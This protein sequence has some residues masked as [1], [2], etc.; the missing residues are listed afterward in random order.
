MDQQLPIIITS[1]TEAAFETKYQAM[2]DKVAEMGI[3][4]VIALYN[5]QLKTIDSR[6]AELAKR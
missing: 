1:K 2:V 4:E 3:D 6:I 5:E